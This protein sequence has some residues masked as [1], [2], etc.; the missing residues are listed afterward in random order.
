MPDKKSILWIALDSIFVILFAVVFFVLSNPDARTTAVW[1]AF[2]MTI[3]AYLTVVITPFMIQKSAAAADYRRPIY[4]LNGVFFAAML[5]TG[6]VVII[7]APEKWKAVAIV[8]LFLVAIY[9]VFLFSNI[10]ANEYTAEAVNKKAE[11]LK[12][13]KNA[14]TRLKAVLPDIKDK[15]AHKKVERLYDLI[16][17]SQTSSSP[18]VSS[19]EKQVLSGLMELEDVI[20]EGNAERIL[21][22]ADNLYKL[23]KQRNKKLMEL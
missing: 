7:A 9:L 1:I 14:A 22:E 16:N 18:A 10:L 8:Y 20:E 4:L 5:I 6:L 13:V 2:T 3:L 11:D 23:A 21:E 15:E 17:S 12:Y 19:L